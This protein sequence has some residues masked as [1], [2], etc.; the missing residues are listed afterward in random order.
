MTGPVFVGGDDRSGT[1]LVTLVLDSHPALTIG[2]EIEFVEPPSLGEYVVECCGLLE[3]GDPRVAGRGVEARDPQY[4]LGVQ[5]VLQ[6]H[7]FGVAPRQVRTLTE[8]TMRE[9]ARDLVD[10]VDRCELIDRIGELRR[11]QSGKPVWGIKILRHI[12]QADR[13]LTAWPGARFIH[14]VRDG[15]DVAASHLRG[16]RGWGYRDAAEAAAGWLEVVAAPALRDAPVHWV[17]YEDLVAA[18]RATLEPLIDWLGLPWSDRVLAHDK[19]PHTLL[20]H[21]YEHPSAVEA[22]GPIHAHSVGRYR[23]DLNTTEIESFEAV[24]APVLER[25]G[26][27]RHGS[28]VGR[29]EGR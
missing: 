18:P 12:A 19:V 20:E 21:P 11:A 14:V 10:F 13:F 26:Y 3:R 9:V 4:R 2:P 8:Q 16:D 5:F 1:T 15:R 25:L 28:S 6:C 29:L 27:P 7:R 24:A 17:R 23:R 22:A